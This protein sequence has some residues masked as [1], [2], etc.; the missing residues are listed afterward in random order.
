MVAGGGG[1]GSTE[2]A[3]FHALLGLD[4]RGFTTGMAAAR[5]QSVGLRAALVGGAGLGAALIGI[6]LGISAVSNVIG[7]SI[8]GV[9]EYETAFTGIRKTVEATEPEFAQLDANIR[10]LATTIPVG[11]N[12]LARIGQVAGQLGVRGVDN[13]TAFI[14][15][16][17]MIGPTTD[18]TTEEA[19]VGF[20]R[21][22]NIMQ[23]PIENV[24]TLAS[25][26]VRLGNNFATFEPEILN[27]AQRIAVSGQI[28][29]FSTDQVLALGTSLSALGIRAELGGTAMQR[30]L[31]TINSIVSE[32]GEELELLAAV[33]GTTAEEFAERW[34]VDAAGAFQE[35]LAG[36][37]Q[38]GDLAEPILNEIGLASQ[39][40]VQAL[41]AL[42]GAPELVA[43]AFQQAAEEMVAPLALTTEFE[44]ILGTT[45]TSIAIFK[46]NVRELA[47]TLGTQLVAA[48]NAVL[49]G[50]QAV[51]VFLAT[52]IAVTS[53]G[54]GV[55]VTGPG[56]R[57]G[58]ES[59][60]E[61]FL[62][63]LTLGLF[64]PSDPDFRQ[65]PPPIQVD[66]ATIA[67]IGL[68][69]EQAFQRASLES[70][71]IPSLAPNVDALLASQMALQEI[72]QA[73]REAFTGARIGPGGALGSLIAPKDLATVNSLLEDFDAEFLNFGELMK[74][75]AEG[76]E[77]IDPALQAYIDRLT[78]LL[79]TSDEA[80]AAEER[81]TQARQ[82]AVTHVEDVMTTRLVAA[83]IEG[84]DA[85]VAVQRQTNAQMLAEFEALRP[86]IEALTGDI[87]DFT[88][89]MFL[90]M[91]T[92]AEQTAKA[93]D[94]EMA[95][96]TQSVVNAFAQAAG[97]NLVGA[98]G[99]AGQIFDPGQIAA[100][101]QLFAAL[102]AGEISIDEANNILQTLLGIAGAPFQPV[103]NVQIGEESVQDIV[104]TSFTDA[105]AAGVL[106]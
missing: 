46:S 77:E 12:E 54:D 60:F 30:A 76:T 78:A 32:T 33:A 58:L 23:E 6:Q 45:A 35:F 15:T 85:A 36:L 13:L 1:G 105:Q 97:G 92:A 68:A 90:S 94:D 42:A 2:V 71:Q 51:A 41:L 63:G 67:E 11:R 88:F 83:F 39:R 73:A 72:A 43:D 95:R 7:S 98:I 57:T 99:S 100:I 62:R 27:F 4:A 19:A 44:R 80:T 84:G 38:A 70:L 82:D 17:A 106:P 53:R 24:G 103:V 47:D 20:A 9:I 40:N 65:A 64:Q 55:T 18:L 3:R 86:G 59:I 25:V 93:V 21:L 52:P 102:A 37:G 74:A 101:A 29:G 16:I 91:K 96:L 104:V 50:L 89:D 81:L 56:V 31:L 48:L 79:G 5:T 22:S 14:E 10:K 28:V 87:A 61:N 34:G 66:P 26:V 69:I 75:G 49:P 8:R